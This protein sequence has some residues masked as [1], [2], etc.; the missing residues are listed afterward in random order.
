MVLDDCVTLAF[1]E[2]VDCAAQVIE[3]PK[4]ASIKCVCFA[5]SSKFST[6]KNRS[7]CWSLAVGS[8]ATLSEFSPPTI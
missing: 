4:A 2:G 3:M 1:V 5:T 8:S 6:Q 7:L